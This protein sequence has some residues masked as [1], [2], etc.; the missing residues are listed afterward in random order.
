MLV[1]LTYRCCVEVLGQ[2]A[3]VFV[4]RGWFCLGD[5]KLKAFD[6]LLVLSKVQTNL[7]DIRFFFFNQENVA[8]VLHFAISWA[9]QIVSVDKVF[10]VS[11]R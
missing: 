4:W 5:E 3:F 10:F 1:G 6:E 11:P 9:F 8:T 2:K 7:S